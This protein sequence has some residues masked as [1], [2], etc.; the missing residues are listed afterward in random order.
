M[1][2]F[3]FYANDTTLSFRNKNLRFLKETM[4]TEIH[5]L[6]ELHG[7][8]QMQVNPEKFQH[9]CIRN[10]TNKAVKCFHLCQNDAI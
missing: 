2:T 4:E 8:N 6:I 3:Y 9:F 10:K 1:S 7:Y 5:I